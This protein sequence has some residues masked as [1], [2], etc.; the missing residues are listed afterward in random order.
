MNEIITYDYLWQ[1]YQKEKQTNQL[2]LI[3]KT[4]YDDVIKFISTSTQTNPEVSL[5]ENTINL[6]NNFFEKR[7]QKIILYVAYNR[8]L[9]QPISSNE[10]EFYNKLLQITKE[11][12][13][14][15]TYS[16][17]DL[18]TNSLK[19]IR[20]IPEIILPSG[21][22]VGP[23]KKDQIIEMADEQDKTYLVENNICESYQ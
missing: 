23:L 14:D 11:T 12:R 17:T 20:D 15:L 21:G 16:K 3:P 6:I 7:K 19:S 8:P 10:L 18:K 22:K 4:F 5:K 1:A 2:L 9:P 13:L